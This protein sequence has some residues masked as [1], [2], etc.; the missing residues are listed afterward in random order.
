MTKIKKNETALNN[1]WIKQINQR[2]NINIT[3]VSNNDWD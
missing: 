3:K 2:N 1:H